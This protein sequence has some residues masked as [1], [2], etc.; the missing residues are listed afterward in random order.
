M[1]ATALEYKASPLR[2]FHEGMQDQVRGL[3]QV[4]AAIGTTAGGIPEGAS[5]SSNYRQQQLQQQQGDEQAAL[6]G[7]GDVATFKDVFVRCCPKF[8][9]VAHAN[10]PPADAEVN[11]QDVLEVQTNMFMK[12]V[13]QHSHVLKLRAVLRV[14]SAL[15]VAKVAA[16]V[17]PEEQ[18]AAITTPEQHVQ[19]SVELLVAAKH[20]TVQLVG[21]TDAAANASPR[22]GA[23]VDFAS[24][25]GNV[26]V[27]RYKEVTK[28]GARLFD[29]I[30]QV[31]KAVAKAA[32][33]RA[34]IK[35]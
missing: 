3:L 8:I 18:V 6:L 21:G 10:A 9:P 29:R 4:V 31:D 30:V 25:A 16:L 11:P 24:T 23:A 1:F 7:Q 32:A 20:K 17:L 2:Y 28:L 14:Y 12:E 26:D 34:A 13:E 19:R 5:S 27:T 22:G 35:K 33:A 15:P